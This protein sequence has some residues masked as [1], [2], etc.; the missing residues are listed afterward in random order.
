MESV[1]R[2]IEERRASGSASPRCEPGLPKLSSF[3]FGGTSPDTR[4][5]VGRE[6]E[7]ETRLECVTCAA[8]SF[9]GFDLID[10]RTGGAYRKEQVGLGMSARRKLPPIVGIPLD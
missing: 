3:L 9:G 8:Y 2:R 6:G 4:L 10:R 1:A 7:L 5:L